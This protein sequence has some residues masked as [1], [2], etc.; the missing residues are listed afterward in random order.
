MTG[1][2]LETKI[3]R[4]KSVF[5]NILYSKSEESIINPSM[6]ILNDL[7]D[8]INAI[9][10]DN[11]CIEVLYTP[12]S[13]HQYFGIKINPNM[14]PSDATIILSSEDRLKLVKY[15]I[16]FD[17]KLF[18]IG[19]SAEEITALTIYEISSMMDSS[20]IFDQVRYQV[21][22]NLVSNDDVIKIRDSIN[23]AQLIIFALKDT[24]YKLSSIMFKE[25]DDEITANPV[26]QACDLAD[27]AV[28]AK[29]K[30]MSSISGVGETLRS[31]KTIILQWMFTM[32]K[33]MQ[34]NSSI[35]VDT[36]RD[37]RLCTGSRLDWK[38]IDKAIAAV[39]RIDMAVITN[40]SLN[41]FFDN[42]NVS[43]LNE[44]SIFK[45]LKRNGLRSIEDDLY[46]FTMKVKNCTTADD[47][48]MILRGI[49]SRLGILED[50]LYNETLK[51][52]ERNHWER[53]AQ[54]Y[55]DLR[56]TLSKKKF[57][58]KAWGVFI[59]YNALDDLDKKKDDKEE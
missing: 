10:D 7:K 24:M 18:D 56:M 41:K 6:T 46:E 55:R 2:M 21:D 31:K 36:L 52:S 8:A 22:F 11:K 3:E 42:H 44:F 49:N 26:L 59:D 27:E 17:S 19:L 51:D 25:E 32:Y 33:N 9:F 50:Y 23:Y 30:I 37:A 54:A 28:S 43:C 20:E 48:F 15:Q 13:D 38:E 40:E 34:T 35:I 1:T 14:S 57:K 4:L 29:N 39:D 53:V 58:E 45:N 16:E 47:A 12:N 5:L